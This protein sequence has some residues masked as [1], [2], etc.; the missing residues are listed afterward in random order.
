MIASIVRTVQPGAQCSH[1]VG[2]F[3]VTFLAAYRPCLH[4]SI[5]SHDARLSMRGRT[6]DE[7][8]REAESLCETFARCCFVDGVRYTVEVVEDES[9]DRAPLAA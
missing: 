5:T 4:S 7:T 1:P 8:L 6:W 2:R 9:A 3:E